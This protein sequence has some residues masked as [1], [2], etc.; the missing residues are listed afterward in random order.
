MKKQVIARTTAGAVAVILLLAGA[1]TAAAW[2]DIRLTETKTFN[3]GAE[4]EL[5]IS[6]ISGDITYTVATGTEATVDIVIDVRAEDKDEAEQIR[7]MIDIDVDGS[8]G[9]LEAYVKYPDDLGRDL[10]RKFGKERSISVS[11]HVT[12]PKDASGHLT[13]VSG[14]VRAEGL[15]GSLNLKTVSGNLDVQSIERRLTVTSVSGDVDVSDCGDRVVVNSV[16]G[17][18]R[19]ANCGGD[20]KARSVS[21]NLDLS[22]I[23][24]EV[25]ANTTSGDIDVSHKSGGMSIQTISGDVSARSESSAGEIDVESMS[26]SV[27]LFADTNKIGRIAL[28]TFSGDIHMKNDPTLEK[29]SR[30]GFSGRGDLHLTLGN[31][32]LDVRAKTHSGDIWIREL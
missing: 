10:R 21:G 15:T 20:V 7:D 12:G 14:D 6:T 22:G 17:D 23:D 19:V 2:E 5:D 30:H 32:D 9:M 24:G 8:D 18:V 29:R 27:E 28:S 13:S 25:A 26:G 31:G 16:S 3:V 4:P 1:S 11:F